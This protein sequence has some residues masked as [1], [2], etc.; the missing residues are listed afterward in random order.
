MFS[1][2]SL[3]VLDHRLSHRSHTYW[4]NYSQLLLN[5]HH[6]QLHVITPGIQHTLWGSF[7]LRSLLS[8]QVS[9]RTTH[10]ESWISYFT[11]FQFPISQFHRTTMNSNMSYFLWKIEECSPEKFLRKES[12]KLLISSNWC[13]IFYSLLIIGQYTTVCICRHHLLS[14][15]I[16]CLIFTRAYSILDNLSYLFRTLSNF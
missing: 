13:N 8:R 9:C 3:L 2:V 10:W 1:Q 11:N 15:T 16:V 4:R 12:T 6:S 7:R 5:P 14:F